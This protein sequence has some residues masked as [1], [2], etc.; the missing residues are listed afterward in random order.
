LRKGIQEEKNAAKTN[1]TYKKG[2]F[3]I[4]KLNIQL[5]RNRIWNKRQISNVCGGCKEKSKKIILPKIS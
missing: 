2:K 3:Q 5:Q 4:A 1:I